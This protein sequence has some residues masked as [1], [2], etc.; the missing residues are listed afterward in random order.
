MPES[1]CCV[2]SVCCRLI[3]LC[4]VFAA[5]AIAAVAVCHCCTAWY[6]KYPSR[7]SRSPVCGLW[8]TEGLLCFAGSTPG[9]SSEARVLSWHGLPS[10]VVCV[11]AEKAAF[12]AKANTSGHQEQVKMPIAAVHCGCHGQITP[13]SSG[14]SLRVSLEQSQLRAHSSVHTWLAVHCMLRVRLGHRAYFELR[15]L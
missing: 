2:S 7:Y 9:M 11:D 14:F 3:L 15:V 4:L 13:A 6:T 5:A 12:E 8:T 1:S 10:C